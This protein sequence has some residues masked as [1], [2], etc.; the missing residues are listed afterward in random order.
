[1]VSLSKAKCLHA[2]RKASNESLVPKFQSGTSS[3]LRCGPLVVQHVV[4]F[5][6]QE[7]P[8]AAQTVAS[9]VTVSSWQ[10]LLVTTSHSNGLTI[11][12]FRTGSMDE[13]SFIQLPAKCQ[14]G[15]YGWNLH[16]QE[17]VTNA[18]CGPKPRST[19]STHDPNC[20]GKLEVMVRVSPHCNL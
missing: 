14:E 11:I 16:S 18:A 6:L 4:R 20:T 8:S 5:L 9:N 1:M 12:M 19:D 13:D 3:V 17:G 7:P 15:R 2:S 10:P